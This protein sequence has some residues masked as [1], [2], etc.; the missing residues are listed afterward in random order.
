MKKTI[1]LVATILFATTIF[2]Q[3]NP[4]EGFTTSPEKVIY[5]FEVKNP[6]GQKVQKNDLLVGKFSIKFGDSLVADGAKMQ[7]QPMVKIDDASKI[8]Q[9]DLVD[10]AL[11]MRKGETCTFAF[12][13]DSIEKLF[14][15]NMPPYFQS[16]MY[17]YWTLQIDDIKTQAQQEEEEAQMRK[18]QE[19]QM[20]VQKQI[21]DS[22]A[23]L[24]P[25]IIEKA[26]K[27]YG[28]DNKPV[29]GIYFKKTFS[30]KSK[31]TPKAGDK[32]K[33]HYVGKF[34]DG[35]LFDTS[36]ESA[37]KEAGI[38]TQGRPYE[39]L[40]FTIAQGQMI[41]G[42]EEG[43]KMMNKGDKAIVLLPSKLAYGERG[44]SAIAPHT[45]LIFELELVEIEKGE[46]AKQP[47]N[48][49]QPIKVTP[50]AQPKQV[51]K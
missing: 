23:V 36:V 17:A 42:F 5:K 21:S 13:K 49:T 7:S 14:G 29:N 1:L 24:E 2:A 26:I 44:Q 9:G 50:K 41:K 16:G 19:E 51:K 45:P 30:S 48:Q 31:E 37:A 46:P 18:V 40:P 47:N 43:V 35:K 28:F 3:K 38:Y 33:V 12:A 6:E 20:K 8:F 11:L 27:D 25:A 34:T 15:G 22:M 32:V 10:G 4:L 39:P